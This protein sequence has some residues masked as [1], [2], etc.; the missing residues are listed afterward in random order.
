M[1]QSILFRRIVVAAIVTGMLGLLACEG[2]DPPVFQPCQPGAG[3]WVRTPIE[4]TRTPEAPVDL[5]ETFTF[6]LTRWNSVIQA[7]SQPTVASC[8][9]SLSGQSIFFGSGSRSLATS[10]SFQRTAREIWDGEGPAA[11][12]VVQLAA[13]GFAGLSIAVTCGASRGCSATA[14]AGAAGGCSSLGDASATLEPKAI[15]ARLATT[16]SRARSRSRVILG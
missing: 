5:R 8:L 12:R 14:S 9:V 16:R 15:G 10:A 1:S 4:S 3:A 2:G 6:G 7:S 13:N 11:P